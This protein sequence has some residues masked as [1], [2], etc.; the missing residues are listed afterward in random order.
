MD[1]ANYSSDSRAVIKNAKEVAA[2]FRHPEIE[3]EH[4]LIA[5][6]RHEGSQVESILN[7]LGK[8]PAFIESVVETYLKDQA[9]RATAR[10]NLTISPAVEQVLNQAI[11]EKE[12]LY[13]ALVEP[14]HIFIAIF[15]PKSNLAAYIRDKV[16]IT[17]ERIYRAIADSKSVEEI[18]TAAEAA[19]GERVEGK[20]D[21]AK[22]LRYCID[23]TNQAAAGE[24]DPV[25]GRD[26]EIQ[27]TV[28]ILL[29]R[30]KN[31]PVL[32]G[33]PGWARRPSSRGSPRRW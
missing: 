24:F 32:I 4:L 10:E 30:R 14:E 26:K 15:D 22:T 16:D 21:V 1:I 33:G 5:T 18:T 9:G 27:Q 11:G 23:L 13:D 3:V 31:S 17:K 7:E 25:I 29:R 2:T 20:K 12:K 19:K 8:S 28:Q 6:L